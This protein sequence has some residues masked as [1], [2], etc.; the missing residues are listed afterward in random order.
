MTFDEEPEKYLDSDGEGDLC[1]IRPSLWH[2]G[3]RQELRRPPAFL[4]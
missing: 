3:E 1:A 4:A 2:E